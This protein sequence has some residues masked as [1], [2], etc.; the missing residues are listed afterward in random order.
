MVESDDAEATTLP[1]INENDL[2]IGAPRKARRIFGMNPGGALIAMPASD[3][4]GREERA[5][6]LIGGDAAEFNGQLAGGNYIQPTIRNGYNKMWVF[7][8]GIS[9]PVMSVTTFMDEAEALAI[10]DD[11]MDGPGIGVWPRDRAGPCL[12]QQLSR[13]SRACRL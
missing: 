4:R 13:L 6:V 7:Q 9:G 11:T 12:G 8:E 2:V 1:A 3:F 10:A 5:Q